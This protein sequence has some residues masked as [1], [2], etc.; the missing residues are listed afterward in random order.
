MKNFWNYAQEHKQPENDPAQTAYVLPRDYGYE[1]SGPNGTI[2][3]LFPA[4]NLSAKIWNDTNNLLA[5]YGMKLDVVYETRTDS[6]STS[7]P[8]KTLIF[9]NGTTINS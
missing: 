6:V 5:T 2:W 4:D 9:W 7:L 8:Y 3:G 1:F